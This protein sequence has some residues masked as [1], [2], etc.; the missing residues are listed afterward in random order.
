M[1]RMTLAAVS[2]AI[3]AG[4][5]VSAGQAASAKDEWAAPDQFDKT[6]AAA[7]EKWLPVAIIFHDP[8]STCPLHNSRV[9]SY[10]MMRELNG[11]LKVHV[12][13]GVLPPV[14]QAAMKGTK[15]H[16]IP[17][18]LV[19]DSHG[20]LLAYAPYETS[21]ADA[22][23]G[24]TQAAAIAAWQ[25]KAAAQVKAIE[26]LIDEAKLT[27]A[28]PQL[29]VLV[30]QDQ[31][32]TQLVDKQIDDANQDV[33][34]GA[35]K[36]SG[37]APAKADPAAEKPPVEGRFFAQEIVALRA[38]LNEKLDACLTDI[39]TLIDDGQLNKANAQ[40]RPYLRVTFGEEK[41]AAIKSLNEKLRAAQKEDREAEKPGA[42]QASTETQ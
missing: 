40:L 32:T 2:V 26:K 30:K 36:E 35:A 33:V 25:R 5:L 41:D 1:V 4:L 18:L 31:K 11:M 34:K 6:M 10:E 9:S 38:K 42:E 16:I 8:A 12:Y 24:A 17:L 13:V 20:R 7:K 22:R 28:A 15:S 14:L 37:K 3:V 23:K 27:T 39:E 21:L 19:L 29:D